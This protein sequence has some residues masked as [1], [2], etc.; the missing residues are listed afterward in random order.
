[1][2]QKILLITTLSLPFAA[3]ADMRQYVAA[4]DNSSWRLAE[5]TPV[6]CRLEHDIPSYG[7][8]VFISEASKQ[9]NLHFVLDMWLKPDAVTNAKLMSKSPDWRPG[10]ASTPITYIEYKKHFNGEVA[11]KDAWFMLNEL[12]RGMQPTFYYSDWY[13]RNQQVAVGLSSAN[14][15]RNYNAFKDCLSRLLPYGYEDIAFTVLNYES[16]GNDLTQ[17]SQRQLKRVQEYLAYDQD[18]DLVL[19][20]AYTDSYGSRSV[21]QRVAQGRAHSVKDFMIAKG[22]PKERIVTMA[23]GEKRPVATNDEIDERA[24]NRRVVIRI[25]KNS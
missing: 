20:D 9:L 4:I 8:A 6:Q 23:H 5:N 21:N 14:F 15:K 12:E 25:N 17:I 18:V 10:K 11:K 13:N 16:G 2:W 3:V 1:M 24:K 19:V 7:K 22:I